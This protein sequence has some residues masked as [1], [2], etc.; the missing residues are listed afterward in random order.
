M[1]TTPTPPAG[2]AISGPGGLL[3]ALP[4]LLGYFPR[5]ELVLVGLER[6]PGGAA[7]GPVASLPL[8][9]HAGQLAAAAAI[10]L[11]RTDRGPSADDPAAAPGP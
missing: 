10:A 4:G 7:L 1:E 9:E 6:G 3:A 8:R 2:A 11:R 5:D